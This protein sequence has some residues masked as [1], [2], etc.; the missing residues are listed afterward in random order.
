MPVMCLL[1]LA[2][3]SCADKTKAPVDSYISSSAEFT[4]VFPPTYEKNIDLSS[5]ESG[6]YVTARCKKSEVGFELSVASPERSRDV[7]VRVENGG[8]CVLCVGECEIPL[9]YEVSC[10]VSEVLFAMFPEEYT[11][12]YDSSGESTVIKSRSGETYVT[13]NGIPIKIICG[14]REITV[15]DFVSAD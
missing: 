12:S 5:S 11:V 1:P 2:L 10:G 8:E 6:E 14:E 3:F 13:E 7:S 9:S 15:A 4:L